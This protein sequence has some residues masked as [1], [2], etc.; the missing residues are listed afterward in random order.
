MF[1]SSPSKGKVSSIS[2]DHGKAK[3]MFFSVHAFSQNTAKFYPCLPPKPSM[4]GL[5]NYTHNI[6]NKILA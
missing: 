2:S 1:L 3:K 6:N 4:P 5:S